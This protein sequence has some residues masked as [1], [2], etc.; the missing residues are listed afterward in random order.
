MLLALLPSR[1]LAAGKA[2]LAREAA[3]YVVRRFGKESLD[4]GVDVLAQRAEALAVTH[5]DEALTAFRNVGPRIFT[6]VDDAGEQ[7]SEVIRLMARYGDE[8]A[9]VAT[10]PTRLAMV[11]AHGDDAARAL[12]AHGE[13]A[14]PLIKTFGQ[15]AA[16]AMAE[17][18]SQNARRLAMMAGDGELAKIG[19]TPEL[20]A[21][22][23]RFPDKAMDFIWNNKGALA[24][25]AVMA[26]FLADPQPFL[27]GTVQI[28]SEVAK[29]AVGPLAE[30]PR[31][32][33]RGT[34]WTIIIVTALMLLS[35]WLLWRSRGSHVG[36]IK[37]Q[38]RVDPP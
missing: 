21:V 24:T 35:G 33:A 19:R 1:S 8:A 20:L 3:E 7:G 31:E 16:G 10:S 29:H 17:L 9:F 23:Q 6:M 13:I 25:A 5:G 18:S 26:T 38:R 37:R 11:S 30:V 15:P 27:D 34:N 4:E 36:W 28:S 12:I 22:V 32:I 2:Q 14:E